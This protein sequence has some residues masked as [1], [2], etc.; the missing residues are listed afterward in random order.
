MH[1]V[2]IRSIRAKAHAKHFAHLDLMLQVAILCAAE[3]ESM[4]E[5]AHWHVIHV[6]LVQERARLR[7]LAKPTQPVLAHGLLEDYAAMAMG[8]PFR[9]RDGGFGGR[10]HGAGSSA[11][12]VEVV[13]E[14]EAEAAVAAVH[15]DRGK[16]GGAS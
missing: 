2:A 16:V 7:F 8:Q 14:V 9:D 4:V 1:V 6:K 13:L 5:V 12:G 10:G 3:A 11:D 15:L